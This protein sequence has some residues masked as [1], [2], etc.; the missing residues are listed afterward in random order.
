MKRFED[1]YQTTKAEPAAFAR[2]YLDYV[3]TLLG[4]LDE[5]QV[6]KFIDAL[7]SA[8]RRQATVFFLGN[9]G[10]AATAAHFVNDLSVGTRFEKIGLRCMSLTDNVASVTAIGNDYGYEHIFSRQ[11]KTY[12][13]PGDLVVAISA[14][15]NSPNLL[16]GIEFARA[17][18]AKTAALVGFDGGRLAS[19]CECVVLA[20][21]PKGEYGPVE[22]VH[23]IL[24]HLSMAYLSA[25]RAAE[26]L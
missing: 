6:G 4:S 15:G 13:K 21:T 2:G 8:H 23:M 10:S 14:S 26:N 3:A 25:Y 19:I 24:D 20:R 22:D 11:L 16:A 1:L 9:G 12:L 5:K 7:M 17:N 18:G